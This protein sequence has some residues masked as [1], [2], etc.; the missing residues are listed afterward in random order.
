MQSKLIGTSLL[1]VTFLLF[2][3][4]T[5]VNG[6]GDGDGDKD[7]K[8]N[9]ILM[10][11][12]FKNLDKRHYEPQDLN[13]SF[14]KRVFKLYLDQVDY[15]K[16]FLLKED[17]EQLN[18]Y[19]TELDDEV[20]QVNYDFLD[21]AVEL[22]NKRTLEAQAYYQE[23]LAEPFQ[24][25]KDEMM[26]T[27]Y[28][29]RDYASS[30]EE[31]KERWRQ[32]LKYQTL[33]RYVSKIE[34]QEDIEEKLK[35]PEKV[36]AERLDTVSIK[37]YAQLEEEARKS[38]LKTQDNWFKRMSQKTRNDQMASYL[39]ALAGAYDPHTSYFAPKKKEDFDIR[40]SGRLEGIGAT[41]NQ[42]DGYIRV[43]N[44]VPGGP[45]YKQGQLKAEDLI[46]KVGQGD[47]EPTD[48]VDMRLDDA[49]Q[50]I[51]GKKGTKVMLT[52]KKVDGTTT[53]IPIIRDV[54]IIEE[55][56]AKSSIIQEKEDTERIGYIK[57]PRFYADF[58]R[59]T[60]RHCAED[61]EKELNK[62]K[63]QNVNGIILDLRNNGGGSLRDVVDM[64]GF[65][66]EEGPIVQ[67]KA[68]GKSPEILSDDDPQVQYDGPLIVMVNK[69]SAS[70]SEILAAALQDYGRAVIVGST[71]TYGKGTVQRFFDLDRAIRGNSEIK[72]LGQVKMTI[73]KFYRVNGGSTQLKGVT[74]DIVLPDNYAYIET[75]ERDQDFAMQWTE[76]DNIDYGQSVTKMKNL[77]TLKNN[78]KARVAANEAFQMVNKN[79][80][81]LETQ[82]EMTK[83]PLNLEAYQ[84]LNAERDEESKKYKDIFK[85]IDGLDVS[86]L[87]VDMP[88]IEI[89]ESK[90]ARND[91]WIKDLK[92]D[93]Y[94]EE[95]LHIMSD[96][97]K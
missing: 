38:I 21:I 49:V 81:R 6:D 53:K 50:L 90:K 68:R 3:F 67:V 86:N 66:I 83:Y 22:I 65:F 72:P 27:D 23:I 48:I 28:D 75:G 54:V 89:D 29:N 80:K 97:M 24:F 8:K 78:S 20:S 59:T 25:D 74:P 70:A 31:L 37:S 43:V 41:L 39:N 42:K 30:K 52:V 69:F 95:C 73:Q 11:L 88:D 57:L 76:I 93:A 87:A 36:K 44:V 18:K 14:S 82:K 26:S 84:K 63:D 13:N 51:R 17:F 10:Q 85:D 40:L 1:L 71:S 33:T 77:S 79:A 60:G 58:N 32:S 61:I 35:D 15:Y 19:E 5:P 55:G 92:K 62:L 4:T 47:E 64:T 7:N 45:A 2:G 12:M 56:Y 46:L 9:E 16:R 34:E 91:E 96:M 94:I